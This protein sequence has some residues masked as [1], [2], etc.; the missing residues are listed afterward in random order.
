M[1]ENVRVYEVAEEAGAT[2][3]DVI[4]KAKDLGVELKSAQSTVS[5]EDAEEITKYIMTGK[6]SKLQ[7]KP[8]AVK[9]KKPQSK[10]IEKPEVEKEDK[11]K[12][13]IPTENP[14]DSEKKNEKKVEIKET[15][16]VEEPQKES[17]SESQEKSQDEDPKKDQEE[18]K[19]KSP[20]KA[21]ASKRIIPKRGKIRI[22]KKKKPKIE[23]P[24]SYDDHQPK[25]KMKSLSEILGS[26]NSLDDNSPSAK[27]Q[28]AKIQK[29][30]TA[31]KAQ[32]HGKV[33][34]I[35]HSEKEF[36]NSNDSLLGEEIV[37]LDMA[38]QDKS[39]LF[40]DD[41]KKKQQQIRT[42][43]PSAF[44]NRPQGLRRKRRKSKIKRDR[45]II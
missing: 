23:E 12:E 9:A 32:E 13:E 40:E 41:N 45:E 30:K 14:T 27:I 43:R 25:K 18:I 7:K 42:T 33:L 3:A 21:V 8:E 26:N 1:S 31:A 22:V 5:F 15:S 4:A 6:S 20:E 11:S 16:K 36:K 34:K 44:G 39:K 17:Q 38:S 28:K 10:K 29:K 24:V 2:T 35:D 19:E 37:L